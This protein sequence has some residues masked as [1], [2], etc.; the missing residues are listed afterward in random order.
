MFSDLSSRL[1]TFD[2][3]LNSSGGSVQYSMVLLGGAGCDCWR[4]Y[5]RALRHVEHSTI[6]CFSFGAW[7]SESE[8]DFP[9]GRLPADRLDVWSDIRNQDMIDEQ[10]SPDTSIVC[11][12]APIDMIWKERQSTGVDPNFVLDLPRIV[13]Q[14]GWI[15][16][17]L[18]EDYIIISFLASRSDID[19]VAMS[20]FGT[21]DRGCAYWRV[22]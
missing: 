19:C 12:H 8:D 18:H 5:C 20:M 21:C 1:S 3:R 15:V 16:V 11:T 22:A 17:P 10:P 7:Y 6:R 4:R 2:L 14:C 9:P 13:N